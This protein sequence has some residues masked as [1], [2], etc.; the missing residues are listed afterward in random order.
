[1]PTLTV[2][3]AINI[4]ANNRSLSS[5]NLRIFLSEECFSSPMRFKSFGLSEK[6]AISDPETK[7]EQHNN[8]I[9]NNN[10]MMALISGTIKSM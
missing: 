8:N 1:M 5:R 3:L 4:V 2:L 9:A 10:E 6:K 7:A